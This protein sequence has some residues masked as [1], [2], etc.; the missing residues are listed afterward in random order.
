MKDTFSEIYWNPEYIFNFALLQY[1]RRGSN[2]SLKLLLKRVN[3]ERWKTS[4]EEI[5]FVKNVLKEKPPEIHLI[6]LFGDFIL[7]L[8]FI[9]KSKV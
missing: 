7:K 6:L 9:I 4:S 8:Y 3:F 2:V 5:H 1:I